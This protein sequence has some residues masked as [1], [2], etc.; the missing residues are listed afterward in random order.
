MLKDANSKDVDFK[1]IIDKNDDSVNKSC[2]YIHDI[3][4][5]D[6]NDNDKDDVPLLTISEVYRSDRIMNWMYCIKILEY[7]FLETE[8]CSSNHVVLLKNNLE[9]LNI[10]ITIMVFSMQILQLT[11][12]NILYNIQEHNMRMTKKIC[13]LI[14]FIDE[15]Y[16]EFYSFVSKYQSKINITSP[17]PNLLERLVDKIQEYVNYFEKKKSFKPE[18]FAKVKNSL[19][20]LDLLELYIVDEKDKLN[21]WKEYFL[22]KKRQLRKYGKNITLSTI[23]NE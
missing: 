8:F 17:A 10:K 1:N 4:K 19:A 22:T 9:H 3:D 7:I 6:V 11:K 5:N 16:S 13:S 14:G 18:D 2:N 21:E 12:N 20:L 23:L 15:K